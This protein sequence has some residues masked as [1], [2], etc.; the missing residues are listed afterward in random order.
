MR[1]LSFGPMSEFREPK[2]KVCKVDIKMLL[3][4]FCG[5]PPT[6]VLMTAKETI[7]WMKEKNCFHRWLLPMNGLHDGTPYA[8]RPVGNSPEFMPLDNSLNRDILHSL[9]FRCVLSRF[10]LDEEGTDE[11][12]RNMRFSFSTPKE[13]ARGLKRIRESK[14][15]TPS[16]ARIIQ[17]VD[18]T[19]KALEMV[20]SANVAAVEGLT[21]RNGHI[22]KVV[23][24]G[25]SFS[26]GGARTK[27]KGSECELTKN[28]FLHSDLLKLC[29]K[30]KRKIN[31]FF[32]DTTVFYY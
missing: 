1:L 6:L 18:L 13:I 17:D 22:R 25:G 3:E 15:G 30:K 5:G 28:M 11:E 31:E 16:L 27:G 26:W 14:M 4:N 9:R 32:P 24:E 12:E 29:L 19:L 21:D 8:G 10:L 23:G 2:I 7:K 20:Y